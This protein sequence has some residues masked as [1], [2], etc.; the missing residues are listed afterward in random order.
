MKSTTRSS[1]DHYI[2]SQAETHQKI[3][4][5]VRQTIMDTC[6]EAVESINYAMPA[7]KYLGKPLVYFAIYPTHLGFYATPSGNTAF[8]EELAWYKQGKGSVQF[9]LDKAIPYDLIK[10]IVKFKKEEIMKG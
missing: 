1:V 2:T 5:K 3:L 10:K 9:P 8:K 4:K 7:Y 6:P